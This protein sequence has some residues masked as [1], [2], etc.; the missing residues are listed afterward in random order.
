MNDEGMLFVFPSDGKSSFWMKDMLFSIDM[1]WIDADGRVVFIVPDASPA[2]Y[3]KSCT[4]TTQSRY[5]L[6]LPAGFAMQHT[7]EVG[8]KVTF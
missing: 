6:E 4:P 7:I 2:S 1:L 8:S 3:P 5:V